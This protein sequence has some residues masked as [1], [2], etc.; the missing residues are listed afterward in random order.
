MNL[1]ARRPRIDRSGRSAAL[2]AAMACTLV[3][4]LTDWGQSAGTTEA[5]AQHPST[6]AAWPAAASRP[7]TPFTL[8]Q[9][10]LCLSGLSGCYARAA[11][12]AVV[13]EAVARIRDAHPSAVTFNE[14]CR[15]DT[16]RIARRTGYHMRFS[17]AIYLGAPLPCIQPDGRGLFGNAVLTKARID[18][19]KNRAFKSQF[20]IE[21]RRWLCV[22]TRRD[23][24]VCT[25]HLNT[26]RTPT[27][28][29]TNNQQCAELVAL[30]ARRA[31]THAVVFGGDMNR[32][33]SCA[34]DRFWTRT[35]K[36][37]DQAPDL[38]HV[39]GSRSALR[40]PS[41]KVRP[42]R[43]SDHDVLLIRARLVRR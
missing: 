22:T 18:A 32:H 42:A 6:S 20:G 19:S 35:D 39:Y 7:G 16:A 38:Q 36:S 14:A 24:A 9:M 37:A 4:A 23:V 1:L 10:N 27:L 43:Y 2:V 40:W 28:R 29:V 8:M 17:R 3:L 11:Y 31:E 34:P 30:L 13:R 12:P 41:A 5:Q 15:R 25:S 21:Q 33:R 26:R